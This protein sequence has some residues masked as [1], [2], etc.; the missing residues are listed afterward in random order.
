MKESPLDFSDLYRRH[1]PD[2]LRFA[3]YLSGDRAT[4]ED[5]ASETFM[6][7]WGARDRVELPTVRAYLLA[8]AR[9]LY[10]QE[11]REARRREPI[12]PWTEELADSGSD[13]E[14]LRD[15]GLELDRILA[16][17][18]E[19]PEPDRAALLLRSQQISYEE[20]GATLGIT[21]GAA[22]VRVHRAR[23]RLSAARS[24]QEVS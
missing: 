5:I 15:R 8:I 2:V 21:P 16:R 7:I 24:S 20:I 6:R 23:I 11:K 18:Q 17:L 3:L 14:Q 12:G 4:A 9:N 19:L 1:A 22:R 13:A 10:L